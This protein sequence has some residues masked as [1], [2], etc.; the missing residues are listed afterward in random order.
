MLENGRWGGIILTAVSLTYFTENFLRS[1]PSALSPVL[2]EELGLTYA[3]TGSLIASFFFIYALMQIPSGL[4]SDQYGSRQTI[5]G[6]TVLTILGTILFYSSDRFELLFVAQLL[7]GL[8]SSVF[9]INA[10]QIVNPW[11]PSDRRASAIGIL[12]A[13]SGLGNFAA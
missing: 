5:I 7:M 8:G 6:F 1:A 3:K 13:T 11:F 12:S 2:M 4:L 9:Y 10:V